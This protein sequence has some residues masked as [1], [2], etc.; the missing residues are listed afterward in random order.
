[1]DDLTALH[2]AADKKVADNAAVADLLRDGQQA[3]LRGAASAFEGRA[4]QGVNMT[5]NPITRGSHM[6]AC[7]DTFLSFFAPLSRAQAL[8]EAEKWTLKPIL[9]F[10]DAEVKAA[11]E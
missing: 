8:V 3:V 7:L 2:D 11:N 10:V 1:M 5:A 4:T 6:E 9:A